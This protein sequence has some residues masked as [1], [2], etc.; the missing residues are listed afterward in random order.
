M[1]YSKQFFFTAVLLVG[2]TLPIPDTGYTAEFQIDSNEL[3][4]LSYRLVGPMRGGRATRVA[5]ISGDPATYYFG[6]AAGGVW[7]TTDGGIT[8]FPIFD[9]QPV[10]AIGDIALAP[11]DPDIIYV[12][13]GDAKS[14]GNDSHGNG[15]YKSID[16]GATW[17]HMGLSG[18]RQ[19]SRS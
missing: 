18:V 19:T 3:S 8:W 17:Q 1:N 2:I 5:G 10:S 11:S 4:G 6:T 12:A 15:V 9:G 7:K 16:A 14:R 13:T